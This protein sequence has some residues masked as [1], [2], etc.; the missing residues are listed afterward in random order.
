MVMTVN[1]EA[2]ICLAEEC[3][4]VTQCATKLLRFGFTPNNLEHLEKEL[5]DIL[6][7]IDWLKQ[8][9]YVSDGQLEIYKHNKRRKLMEFSNLYDERG[10]AR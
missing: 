7:L 8:K 1:D 9:G 4:E 2:L 10:E 3:G 6:C 5:G